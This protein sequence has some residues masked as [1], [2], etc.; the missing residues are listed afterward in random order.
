MGNSDAPF[1]EWIGRGREGC[2]VHWLLAN[3]NNV[4]IVL[5]LV[6]MTGDTDIGIGAYRGGMFVL[7]RNVLNIYWQTVGQFLPRIRSL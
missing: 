4:G 7:D 6:P 1:L 3:I 2:G 5:E